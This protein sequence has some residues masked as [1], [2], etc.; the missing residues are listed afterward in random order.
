MPRYFNW[1]ARTIVVVTD[2]V[3]PV[4]LWGQNHVFTSD[5]TQELICFQNSARLRNLGFGKVIFKASGQ[6]F[7]RNGVRI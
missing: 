3:N 5:S 1:P 2:R 7:S 6:K 4:E